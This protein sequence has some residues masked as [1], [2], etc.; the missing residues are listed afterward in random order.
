M[1]FSDRVILA[2]Y[3]LHSM[4]AA[5]LSGMICG[6]IQFGLVGVTAIA[7]VFVGQ[8]NG[9]KQFKKLAHPVWQMTWFALSAFLLTIPLSLWS[10]PFVIQEP[11]YE[12]A[13]PYF[14][15]LMA[16]TPLLGVITAFSSFFIGQGNAKIVT[17]AAFVSN[18]V[19]VVLDIVLVFG[20]G[21]FPEMGLFGAALATLISQCV[22]LLIILAVYYN[23]HNRKHF[24]TH[25]MMFDWRLLKDC[26][27]IGFPSAGGHML[28]ILAWTFLFYLVT[29]KGERYLTVIAV[30][31]TLFHLIALLNDGLY[32][33]SSALVA[34]CIGQKAW[35]EI[36]NVLKSGLLLHFSIMAVFSLLILYPQL[37]I[38]L[39]LTDKVSNDIKQQMIYTLR[40]IWLFAGIDGISWIVGGVLTAGGDTRF[41]M[42]SGG[43]SV[44]L[45]SIVPIYVIMAYFPDFPPHITWSVCAFYSAIL[46]L[47]FSW[48]YRSGKWI[49]S[50][51]NF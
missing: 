30:G 9:A 12:V 45:F 44:W 7:E 13:Q 38:N 2:H 51:H 39:F 11:Y 3:S 35:S 48:R 1:L 14:R 46:L 32:K 21:H 4:N 23:S 26:L 25:K 41:I 42:I 34:N 20:Y 31:Q 29:Q 37:V 18:I 40:W 16:T 36:R 33:G 49:K 22:Q 47:I 27:R 6:L 15:L 17:C 10:G 5:A 43:I 24:F 8:F 50:I 28:E 19:N